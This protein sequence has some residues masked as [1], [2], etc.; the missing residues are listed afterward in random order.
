MKIKAD[1]KIIIL[2]FGFAV[3]SGLLYLRLSFERDVKHDLYPLN[4]FKY[5]KNF[6]TEKITGLEFTKIEKG[7]FFMGSPENDHLKNRDEE[8]LTLIEVDSFYISATEVSNKDFGLFVKDT[9]YKTTSEKEGFS[10]IFSNLTGKWEKKKGLSWKNPGYDTKEDSPVVHVSFFDAKAFADWLTS[11]YKKRVFR[12]PFEYEWEYAAKE[13]SDNIS[14][15]YNN[16]E[17]LCTFIN[18]ADISAKN[19]F[20]GWKINNCNDGFIF[21]APVR[22]LKP[23]NSGLYNMLGNVWE[24]CDSKYFPVIQKKNKRI[25]GK[26]AKVVIRGGS[27]YSK[28]K[29]LRFTERDYLSSPEKRGYDIGFRIVMTEN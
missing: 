10:W 15:F 14:Y 6:F 2:I 12:L 25:Y 26:K 13:G 8:P 21:T 28:P 4:S 5:K 9:G 29:Y 17:T 27:F 11:K 23:S 22:Y 19:Y 3:F 20:Q 16:N 1:Y 7:S 18:G 24:W